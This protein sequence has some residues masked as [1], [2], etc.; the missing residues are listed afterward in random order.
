[1]KHL[2]VCFFL[3]Q[4]YSGFA[5][6][7]IE[8]FLP[9]PESLFSVIGYQLNAKNFTFEISDPP[10]TPSVRQRVAKTAFE[11]LVASVEC[12]IC[13][14]IH[15]KLSAQGRGLTV[16]DVYRFRSRRCGGVEALVKGLS[17][18]VL[19]RPIDTET[20][21]CY[22]LWRC[23]RCG[24]ENAAADEVCQH[25]H[26]DGNGYLVPR[27]VVK[28][29]VDRA[30]DLRH[31]HEQSSTVS[32]LHAK[33]VTQRI[34]PRL[35]GPNDAGDD[36]DGLIG[37]DTRKMSDGYP[38]QRHMYNDG[39]NFRDVRCRSTTADR[40]NQEPF[41]RS[42]KGNTWQHI[43]HCDWCGAKNETSGNTC[44]QCNRIQSLRDVKT[45]DVQQRAP[46]AL[47]Q[48][49]AAVGQSRCERGPRPKVAEENYPSSWLCD[50]CA[51]ENPQQS[52][53]CLSCSAI[54]LDACRVSGA[55]YEH[56]RVAEHL[57]KSV[58]AV[59]Q[60]Q[61]EKSSLWQCA[62]CTFA[63]HDKKDKCKVCQNPRNTRPSD[64]R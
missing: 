27:Y 12:K 20:D 28:P 23:D 6:I 31:P 2:F 9:R 60:Q 15:Q 64:T 38:Y 8:P 36:I 4:A 3:F 41:G 1:M 26:F 54:R 33:A 25:C 39:L 57:Q 53:T 49:S 14:D 19:Q 63:N 37:D 17:E 45:I 24:K 59:R 18:I 11:L 13:S 22:K 56:T 42:A 61:Q 47:H 40:F 43:W 21:V 10:L 44:M 7:R 51:G 48:G 34:A 58:R 5:K 62:W 29:A 52:N 55:D 30:T 35:G 50:K 46:V 32:H 16:A